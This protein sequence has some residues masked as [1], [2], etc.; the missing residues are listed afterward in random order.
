[1]QK[2]GNFTTYEYQYCRYDLEDPLW[3]MSFNREVNELGQDC[4]EL[5]STN[6]DIRSNLWAFF[7]R[8]TTWAD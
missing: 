6:I 3:Y 5:V 2:F 4:W 1:M 7:K 8:A